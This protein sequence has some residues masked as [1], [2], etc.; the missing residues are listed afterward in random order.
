VLGPQGRRGEVLAELHTDFPE[1]FE[2]RRQLWAL[3]ADGARRELQLEEHWFH[4][5]GVV[6][7]FAGVDSIS[8][9][10]QLARMELQIPGEQLAELEEGAAF[11]SELIGCQ[12]WVTTSR[13]SRMLGTVR[14]LQFGAGEAPLLVIYR[15][16][17]A[18]EEE[19]LVPYAAEFV[20]SSDIPQRR[21]EMQLPDG[22]LDLEVPLSEEEKKRQKS[23]A[24][25]VRAAGVRRKPRRK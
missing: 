1:R 24:E 16:D 19:I 6:L 15:Q 7:K 14:D 5:G 20:K 13:G 21:I 12:V 18:K 3:A 9:A 23:E 11:V 8:D 10:E 17:C 2:Q 4:K 25:E 22:L